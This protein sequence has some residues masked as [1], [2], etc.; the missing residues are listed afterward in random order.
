MR[1]DLSNA[2]AQLERQTMARDMADQGRLEMENKCA[3]L[4]Q[5]EAHARN[6]ATELELQ[7]EKMRAQLPALVAEQESLQSQLRTANRERVELHNDVMT[8]LDRVSQLENEVQSLQGQLAS[9]AF[10]SRT[11]LEIAQASVRSAERTVLD[12]E[13]RSNEIQNRMHDAENWK[14]AAEKQIVALGADVE[15]A[16]RETS[17]SAS[18]LSELN[19]KYM[20]DLVALD[21]HREQNVELREKLEA[22]QAENRRLSKFESLYK[23]SETQLVGLRTR[24]EVLTQ[25]KMHSYPRTISEGAAQ[26]PIQAKP[27]NAPMVNGMQERPGG[28]S[29]MPEGLAASQ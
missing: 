18:R 22:V 3:R 6:R 15:A 25:D 11:E 20:T 27:A 29:E 26:A 7:G 10:A 12:Y 2:L 24:V 13:Q 1:S 9:A 5:A 14:R 4:A 23:S 17:A 8:S 21:N 28:A 19:L 16:R